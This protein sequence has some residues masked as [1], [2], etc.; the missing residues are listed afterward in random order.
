[1]GTW[2]SR[3]KGLQGYI[4]T[5]S[6]C[7][8]GKVSLIPVEKTTLCHAIAFVCTYGQVAE[9]S[10]QNLLSKF[11]C[12]VDQWHHIIASS[13]HCI[14]ASSH[15]RIIASSHHRIIASSHSLHN[16]VLKN[17]VEAYKALSSSA[18][19]PKLARVAQ[20]VKNVSITERSS[21]GSSN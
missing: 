9:Q 13:H 4:H 2:C 16:P 21:L 19:R 3:F 8:A 6:S 15:H 7:K 12:W 20:D 10:W 14:I 17:V 1:V 5:A 18:G 11:L